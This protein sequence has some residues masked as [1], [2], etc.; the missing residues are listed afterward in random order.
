[1]KRNKIAL[2]IMGVLAVSALASTLVLAACSGGTASGEPKSPVAPTWITPE[3]SAGT[4]SIPF[5]LVQSKRNT[6]FKVE[7]EKGTAYYMAYVYSGKTHVRADVCVPCRSISFTL[8]K[9]LLVCDS[10]GTTF[11]ASD[12]TGVAGACVRYPK[13]A[14][15]FETVSGKMV[16]KQADLLKA[17][18]DTLQQGLP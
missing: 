8:D 6:H 9:N 13:A 11:N 12:G 14:V 5:D 1:M 18:E 16:M 15:P 17:F 3:V 7:T 2:I 4:V 10:C